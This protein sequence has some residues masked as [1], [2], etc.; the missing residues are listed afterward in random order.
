MD[1]DSGSDLVRMSSLWAK[2]PTSILLIA[3]L[4]NIF[5][6]FEIIKAEIFHGIVQLLIEPVGPEK[7]RVSVLA[8]VNCDR[9]IYGSTAWSSWILENALMPKFRA[10]YPV[11]YDT[12]KNFIIL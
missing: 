11:F 8:L 3:E 4:V 6:E 5:E 10:A 12:M 2:T 7:F 1:I 9:N